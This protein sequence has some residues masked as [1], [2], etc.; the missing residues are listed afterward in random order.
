MNNP[1]PRITRITPIFYTH[2][3]YNNAEIKHGHIYIELKT[4]TALHRCPCGCNNMVY[5]PFVDVTAQPP[6]ATAKDYPAKWKLYRHSNTTIFIP[7]PTPQNP[8]KVEILEHAQDSRAIVS[9][10][11]SISSPS[12]PCRSH[13]FIRKNKVIWL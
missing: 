5:T 12:H 9:L 10:D 8:G 7:A 1:H 13:Y 11:P 6:A 3:D 4:G 2:K